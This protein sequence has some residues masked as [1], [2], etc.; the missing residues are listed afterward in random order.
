MKT[1]ET[2]EILWSDFQT[3]VKD[4]FQNAKAT[5]E[6][7]DV[8]LACDD[9][10]NLIEAHRIILATGSSFFQRILSKGTVH[11]PHPLLFLGGVRRSDLEA[12]LDFLYHGQTKVPQMELPTFL[13]TA[14]ML[15]VK[16][17]Q[18]YEEYTSKQD[19]DI[20]LEVVGD[21]DSIELGCTRINGSVEG[22][23]MLNR[24][25]ADKK[26]LTSEQS[27]VWRFM[28]RLDSNSA[29]CKICGMVAKCI[30]ANTSDLVD[31]IF[32]NHQKEAQT[33]RNDYLQLKVEE[34]NNEEII[35]KENTSDENHCEEFDC[36]EFDSEELNSEGFNSEEFDSAEINSEEFNSDEFDI[37][38]INSD[39]NEELHINLNKSQIHKGLKEG[40]IITFSP[41]T[42]VNKLSLVWQFFTFQGT[43]EMGPDMSAVHCSLCSNKY[44]YNET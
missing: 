7:S 39:V 16:G 35:S 41:D 9:G 22:N 42:V 12:I 33:V 14:R 8:S 40:E 30:A 24:S 34:I 32:K 21:K 10:I 28:D 18:S 26:V 44:K 4:S 27:G 6:F 1:R 5:H 38:D 37:E 25:G 3:N 31:H 36:E 43:K 13:Q 29:L 19:T 20:G 17:L 2:L 15:E 23:K 11:H